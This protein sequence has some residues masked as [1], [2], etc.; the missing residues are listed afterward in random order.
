MPIS[1]DIAEL[2]AHLLTF[3]ASALAYVANGEDEGIRTDRACEVKEAL[4]SARGLFGTVT[5]L[6]DAPG[7]CAPPSVDCGG[8]CLP[9]DMCSFVAANS[10]SKVKI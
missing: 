2:Y 10:A 9:P 8:V 7:V 4:E 6:S 5:L 1:D 3:Q